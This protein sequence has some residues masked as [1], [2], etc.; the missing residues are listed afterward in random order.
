M[1]EI[2]TEITKKIIEAGIDTVRFVV[3]MRPLQ[4]VPILGIAFT[5]SGDEM[6]KQVCRIDE[7]RYEVE[8]NY[9]ITLRAEDPAYGYESFY[10]MDLN[11]LVREGSIE[12]LPEG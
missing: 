9:K 11:S 3:P 5:S 10:L 6:V 8:N 12:F 1:T 4:L 7:T 2:H